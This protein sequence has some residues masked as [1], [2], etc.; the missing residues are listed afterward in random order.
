MAEEGLDQ[1]LVGKREPPKTSEQ[2][3]DRQNHLWEII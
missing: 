3:N 2:R 1:Y